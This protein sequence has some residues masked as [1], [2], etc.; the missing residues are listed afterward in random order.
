ML[1]MDNKA[2]KRQT[3]KQTTIEQKKRKYMFAGS[4]FVMDLR[5]FVAC[6]NFDTTMT[7]MLLLALSEIK[8]YT[9]K[10]SQHKTS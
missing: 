3:N 10:I 4:Q 2:S 6:Q 5:T 7:F 9:D 1:I 8:H